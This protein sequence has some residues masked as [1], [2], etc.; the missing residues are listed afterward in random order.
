MQPIDYVF[1]LLILIAFVRGMINGLLKEIASLLAIVLGIVAGRLL[2]EEVSLLLTEWFGWSKTVVS[3]CAFVIIFL[4]V[5]IGLHSLAF[6]LKK[7]LNAL[8]INWLNRLAGGLFGAFKIAVIVSLV[9]NLCG[10]VDKY[11]V[12]FKPETKEVSVLYCPIEKLVPTLMPLL[13]F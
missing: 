6:L 7:I 2:G 4:V 1:L 12:V 13:K 10:Y 3:I 9:L 8:N 5:A 11:V